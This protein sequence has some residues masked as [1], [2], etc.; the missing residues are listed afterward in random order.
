MTKMTVAERHPYLTQDGRRWA[1]LE[2]AAYVVLTQESPDAA[3]AL[4]PIVEE[5]TRQEFD[6]QTCHNIWKKGS[7]Y[8]QW[9]MGLPAIR[10]QVFQ[11]VGIAQ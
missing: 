10:G 3:H 11:R 9:L 4:T 8:D 2:C 5:N 1:S 7:A 6:F